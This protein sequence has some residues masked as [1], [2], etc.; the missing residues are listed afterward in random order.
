MKHDD[1]AASPDTDDAQQEEE[2]LSP[3]YIPRWAVWFHKTT[4]RWKTAS[5]YTRARRTHC[6]CV[7][8]APPQSYTRAA[9]FSEHSDFCKN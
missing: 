4:L 5:K 2:E 6:R 9:R 7:I 1:C 3:R 8:K